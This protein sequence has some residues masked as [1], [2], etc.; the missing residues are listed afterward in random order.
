MYRVHHMFSCL[1]LLES[2]RHSP[3]SD[4]SSSLFDSVSGTA[5]NLGGRS[6]SGI[7]SLGG[8]NGSTC[9]SSYK[10]WDRLIS[11]RRTSAWQHDGNFVICKYFNQWHHSL[12]MLNA[13]RSILLLVGRHWIIASIHFLKNLFFFTV[14]PKNVMKLP[15]SSIS[16]SLFKIPF[17]F[18]IYWQMEF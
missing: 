18:I 10:G 1:S 13:A 4:H 16:F 8:G 6:G 12:A 7:G 15:W 11:F 3:M 14:G 17:S 9:G 2:S 5:I